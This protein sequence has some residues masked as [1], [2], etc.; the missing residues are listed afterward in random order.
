MNKNHPYVIK[1]P[2][3]IFSFLKE[4]SELDY[5]NNYYLIEGKL[6]KNLYVVPK[7]IE[8]NELNNKISINFLEIKYQ[9]NIKK[10][11]K[12]KKRLNQTIIKKLKNDIKGVNVG[13]TKKLKL[14]GIGFK[15]SIIEDNLILKLGFSHKI[16]IKIPKNITVIIPNKDTIICKG[17]NLEELSSFTTKI[18]NKKKPNIYK[19]QGIFY[20]DEDIKRKPG[21]QLNY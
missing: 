3:I 20:H 1:N 4:K 14:I 7:Y 18:K 16:N 2:N 21:K 5:I 11:N 15:C 12:I 8:L 13:F 10:Y 6:G 17:I 19:D 9:N